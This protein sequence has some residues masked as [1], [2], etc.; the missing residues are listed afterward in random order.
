MTSQTRIFLFF[1][2]FVPLNFWTLCNLSNTTAMMTVYKDV[3][4][5]LFYSNCH[6]NSYHAIRTQ[7]ASLCLLFYVW[8]QANNC[9]SGNE[10]YQ[11]RPTG[12]AQ[13][14]TASKNLGLGAAIMLWLTGSLQ[15][16]NDSNKYILYPRVLH[17]PPLLLLIQLFPFV[18]LHVPVLDISD[19]C[20]Q[21]TNN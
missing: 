8:R 16:P 19:V 2:P 14:D 4:R 9:D 10:G 5:R 18:P 3:E 15:V 21:F 17:H 20:E 12:F 11:C 13:T 7:L 6:R 1:H